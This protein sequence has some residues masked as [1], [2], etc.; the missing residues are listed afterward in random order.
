MSTTQSLNML[1]DTRRLAAGGISFLAQ[2]RPRW[3]SVVNSAAVPHMMTLYRAMFGY[4]REHIQGCV[5]F[6]NHSMEHGLELQN[7][8]FVSGFIK[9][10][11]GR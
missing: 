3:V 2:G 1:H 4:M 10:R 8:M 5:Q 9:T 11:L 7:L 6:A